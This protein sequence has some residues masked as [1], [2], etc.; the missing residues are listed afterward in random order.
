MRTVFS[1]QYSPVG[2][3]S[4]YGEGPGFAKIKKMESDYSQW[5][6]VKRQEGMSIN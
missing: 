5:H 4:L 1:C 6:P 2:P 3:F